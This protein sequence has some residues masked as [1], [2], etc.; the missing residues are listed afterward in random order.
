MTR[1]STRPS[2]GRLLLPR[3]AASTAV[4]GAAAGGSTA[5]HRGPDRRR[6]SWVTD[7]RWS[8]ASSLTR[9]YLLPSRLSTCP[10]SSSSASR[11]EPRFASRSWRNSW[12]KYRRSC[13]FPR[14]SGL[15]SRPWT[16]Q[17]R[18]VVGDTQI[19]KVF[20]E[21]RVQQVSSRSLIFPVEVFKVLA[22]DRV[23]PHRVDG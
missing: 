19:F 2:S 7:A 13:H 10:R 15:W 16:L 4:G 22:L 20:S 6:R 23:L 3:D 18:R 12:W 1:R 9:Y 14:C 8:C 21:D 11:R 17:F 5:A